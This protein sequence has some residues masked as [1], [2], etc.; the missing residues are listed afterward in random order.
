[1][2]LSHNCSLHGGKSEV[3]E[4]YAKYTYVYNCIFYSN[5]YKTIMLQVLASFINPGAALSI[6][7]MADEDATVPLPVS[8][9]DLFTQSCMVPALCSYLRNDS[10]NY[11]VKWSIIGKDLIGELINFAK[12][13]S[14]QMK[15]YGPPTTF[16]QYYLQTKSL[17]NCDIFKTAKFKSHQ[18]FSFN[19][20][21]FWYFTLVINVVWLFIIHCGI[22]IT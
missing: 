2:D 5:P 17:P 20:I 15:K 6:E 12:I 19:S 21:S 8:L 22:V 11:T 10:G 4:K 13:R 18:H 7:N 9:P 1:M 16:F 3:C 14:H